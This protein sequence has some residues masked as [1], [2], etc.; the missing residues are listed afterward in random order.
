VVTLVLDP[1][2]DDLLSQVAADLDLSRPEV[3]RIMLESALEMSLT[4]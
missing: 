1:L 4:R 2:L 3:A